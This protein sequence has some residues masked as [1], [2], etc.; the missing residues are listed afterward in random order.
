M[1]T[2]LAFRDVNFNVITRNNQIWLTSKEL[3]NALG[4]AKT[5]AITHIYNVNSDEFTSG[6]SEIVESNTSGNL[7]ARS[8]IFSLRGAHLIAMF[9]RTEIAKEFRKWVLDI[10]DR[11]VGNTQPEITP[12]KPET[13]T[14]TITLTEKELNHLCWLWKVAD[15]MR[16]GAEA[17]HPGLKA[18]GSEFSGRCHDMAF[19][20]RYTLE[21][22]KDILRR[23]T[24][25]IDSTA[26]RWKYIL[27]QIHQTKH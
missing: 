27:P 4:Y 15:N 12:V 2:Q 7:K 5:N 22:V 10:L 21:N 3:A 23:E 25:G 14:Y 9:A 19:E 18:L 6:M 11:E 8:R 1:T 20:S 16:K 24:K 17:M 26:Y 13:K